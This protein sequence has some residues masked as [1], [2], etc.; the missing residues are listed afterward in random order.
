MKQLL[1][2]I[3]ILGLICCCSGAALGAIHPKSGDFHN[4][5]QGDFVM[6]EMS[7]LFLI[8]TGSDTWYTITPNQNILKSDLFSMDE[9]ANFNL[10]YILNDQT[11]A[12]LSILDLSGDTFTDFRGGYLFDFGLFV[13][14]NY[15]DLDSDVS[16]YTLSPGYRFDLNDQTYLALSFDYT[17]VN[18][19]NFEEI[20]G[21]DLDFAYYGDTAK[22]YAQ[23]YA[24]TEEWMNDFN[25]FDLGGAIQTTDEIVIGFNYYSIDAVDYSD[26]DVGLTWTP[27][28]MTFDLQLG[29][30]LEES[31]YSIS[32][33][34]NV[35]ENIGL[36]LEAFNWDPIDDHR[37]MLKFKY[38]NDA[39]KFIF[40]YV[41]EN[42]FYD[43]AYTLLYEYRFE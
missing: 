11:F 9:I 31:F 16:F 38:Q 27:D 21:Y 28:F 26:Y 15:Y 19:E 43:E 33:I 25:A 41:I 4:W 7:L 24:A 35:N 18:D 36:G 23:Y 34:F 39:S 42:D 6:I 10:D 29:T 37:I 14:L 17:V 8:G 32:G 13:G 22:F 12:G 40:G 5:S 2:A 30:I 1:V 20:S 3:L